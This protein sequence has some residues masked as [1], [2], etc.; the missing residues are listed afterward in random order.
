MK[1]RPETPQ[2]RAARVRYGAQLRQRRVSKGLKL[3]DLAVACGVSTNTI[4][5]W[6]RGE[7]E[8]SQ[9]HRDQ[10]TEAFAAVKGGAA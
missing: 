9:W 3:H 10:L 2:K 7:C 8:V 1:R 6:Q 5:R 4:S